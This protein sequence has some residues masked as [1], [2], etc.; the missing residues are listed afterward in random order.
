MFG[1][2]LWPCT[3]SVGTRGTTKRTCPSLNLFSSPVSMHRWF[4]F[5]IPSIN[6]NWHVSSYQVRNL[7]SRLT[8]WVHCFHPVLSHPISNTFCPASFL[9]N[10]CFLLHWEILRSPTV[11]SIYYDCSYLWTICTIHLCTGYH[12]L[13]SIQEFCNYN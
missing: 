12:P 6:I 7:S 10:N 3:F 2:F 8:F 11:I 4:V 9:S 1:L 13:L 5:H